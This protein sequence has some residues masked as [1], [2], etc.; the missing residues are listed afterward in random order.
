[1]I[2]IITAEYTENAFGGTYW[3]CW[4]EISL[5]EETWML[6]ATAPGELVEGE[7]QAF[8]DAKE[9]ELWAVAQ[10]KQHTVDLYQHVAVKRVL[11]AFALVALDEFN[12][13]RGE[14]SLPERTAEQ[15]KAAIKAKLGQ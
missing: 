11:K 4:L 9:S 1:M 14:H 5:G 10:A 2:E 8:F 12:I 13:L 6:P 3:A 15:L 7:L